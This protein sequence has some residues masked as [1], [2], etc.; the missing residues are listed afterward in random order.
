MTQRQRE[1]E[2]TVPGGTP[3]TSNLSATCVSPGTLPLHPPPCPLLFP[4]YPQVLL[5]PFTGSLLSQQDTNP[6]SLQRPNKTETHKY[7]TVFLSSWHKS[8]KK[9]KGRKKI[10]LAQGSG[11]FIFLPAATCYP[12][13]GSP[14]TSY[15]LGW[16]GTSNLSCGLGLSQWITTLSRTYFFKINAGFLSNQIPAH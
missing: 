4:S 14:K 2:G 16:R 10:L 6:A 15:G 9:K 3:G 1:R 11:V 7:V 5:L 13:R 8:K 12:H